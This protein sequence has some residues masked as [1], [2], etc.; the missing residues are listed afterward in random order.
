MEEEFGNFQNHSISKFESMLKTNSFLFFDSNEYEEIIVYYI[1]IGNI[2]LAKKAISLA[3]KQYPGLYYSFTFAYW[4][5]V[6][7]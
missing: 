2:F 7:K 6:T 4:G 5:F 3:S 1:E